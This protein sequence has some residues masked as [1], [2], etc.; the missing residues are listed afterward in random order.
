MGKL[1]AHW[2]DEEWEGGDVPDG[3]ADVILAYSGNF[4]AE[5]LTEQD[6]VDL[7]DELNEA[8]DGRGEE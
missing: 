3:G 4:V 7:R 6:A 1:T 5:L 2:T 8:L